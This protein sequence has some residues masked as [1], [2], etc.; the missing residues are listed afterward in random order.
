M[1]KTNLIKKLSEKIREIWVEAG[2]K[3]QGISHRDFDGFVRD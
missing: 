3:D 2:I 1:T